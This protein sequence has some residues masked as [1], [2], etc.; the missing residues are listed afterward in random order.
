MRQSLTSTKGM[1]KDKVWRKKGSAHDSNYTSLSM[2][3][4]GGSIIAWTYTAATGASSCN[5]TKNFISVQ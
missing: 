1:K 5:K 2:K 3:H 4:G